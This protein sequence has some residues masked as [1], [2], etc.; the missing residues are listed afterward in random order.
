MKLPLSLGIKSKKTRPVTAAGQAPSQREDPN[1]LT[2][3]RRCC[4]CISSPLPPATYGLVRQAPI[5]ASS[6]KMLQ[7]PALRR[8]ANLDRTLRPLG[9]DL[10][11]AAPGTDSTMAVGAAAEQQ[12]GGRTWDISEQELY[13]SPRVFYDKGPLSEPHSIQNRCIWG[14]IGRGS[15]S[16]L[17]GCR[18]SI[19]WASFGSGT[20]SPP[21]RSLRPSPQ[22]EM[23]STAAR[24]TTRAWL[25][26]ASTWAVIST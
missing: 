19:R 3:G 5:R 23:G 1:Q 24:W 4:C 6:D 8:L 17:I 26:R 15:D 16:L 10:P 25:P 11:L 2:A 18:C 7:S 20:C 12:G 22:P 13:V 21:S 9:G 14:E